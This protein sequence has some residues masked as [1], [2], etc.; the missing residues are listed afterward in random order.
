MADNKPNNFLEFLMRQ[1]AVLDLLEDMFSVK[2]VEQITDAEPREYSGQTV[3]PHEVWQALMEAEG[4][5]RLKV[6]CE[7][8]MS[9][10]ANPVPG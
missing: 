10:K 2:E 6:E 5:Q 4:E 7:A 8:L 3:K 9:M 1:D